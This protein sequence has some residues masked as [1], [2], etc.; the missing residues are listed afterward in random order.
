MQRFKD[1][2]LVHLS[3]N[4]LK[5]M[6]L[7][8]N[9]RRKKTRK[10]WEEFVESI[11]RQGV[12]QSVVGRLMPDNSIELL[13]GYGRRDAA[14][15]LGLEEVPV[16]IRICS[17]A[18]ALE[19]NWAENCNRVEVSF[20]DQI[21]W[22]QRYTSLY[23]GDV[24]TAA[25]RLG[26]SVSKLRERLSL[27]PCSDEVLDALDDGHITVKHALIL[28]AFE[29][30]IQNN[31]LEK[32]IAEKWSVSE[33]KQRADRVQ[34]PL[35]KAIFSQDECKSCIHNTELQAG[36][37][38]MPDSA[39]CSKASCF[40][41]KTQ[42]AL[43][44]KKVQAEERFGT[45]IWLSQSLPEH[46][47]TVTATV[48]GQT[49]FDTGCMG[50]A[51]RVAV[52]DDM[53]HGTPGSML[54]SQCTD[55]SCFNDCVSAYDAFVAAQQASGGEETV[56]E[57]EGSDGQQHNDNVVTMDAKAPAKA[58]DQKSGVISNALVETHWQELR[59]AAGDFVDVSADGKFGLIM[60]L[61][62]LMEISKFKPVRDLSITMPGL[63]AKPESELRAMISAVLDH[64][65]K[66]ANTICGFDANKVM[67]AAA[68]ATDGGA[69]ALIKAW[70]PTENTLKKYTTIGLEQ[71]VKLSGL[72]KHLDA[73]EA[74]SGKKLT[75]GKKG[76][77][78]KGILAVTDF[79]WSHFA[80][81]AYVELMASKTEKSTKAA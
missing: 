57:N 43:E 68:V 65:A 56:S 27:V 41:A 23:N 50:C 76:D 14:I 16:L 74:G 66:K 46:R 39:Q 61:V 9:T 37:F 17:D 60:Q 30:R 26:W 38:G 7:G 69:D 3:P 54:E 67:T 62:G 45:V 15:Q 22:S 55:S 19:I 10:N 51:K 24:E 64:I 53:P 52:I 40:H 71:I 21:V 42:S 11:K 13:A 49:Q 35:S 8:G 4:E 58:S 20:A 63:M 36:L 32:I 18:E 79:D 70:T 2:Q 6:K 28:S 44:V 77:A 25:Q 80:P 12:L 78:I 5:D 48:V 1:G 73:K 33:L 29:H 47:R 59:A 31:T 72:D 75:A 81:P 34:I